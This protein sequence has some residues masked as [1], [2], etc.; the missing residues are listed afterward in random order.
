MRTTRIQLCH[1]EHPS[2]RHPLT[3]EPLIAEFTFRGRPVWPIFGAEDPPATLEDA[4]RRMDSL[5]SDLA[6]ERDRRQ[7]AETREQEARR[8]V[9]ERTVE[10]DRLQQQVNANPADVDRRIAE[11]RT[12][13]EQAGREAANAEWQP[14]L[15]N[16]TAS[17]VVTQA[18]QAALAAG[19]QPEKDAPKDAEG[20]PLPDRVARFL[21]LVDLKDITGDDG[22]V[23]SDELAV[24]IKAA[25]TANPEFAAASTVGAGGRSTF[26]AAPG[27]GQGSQEGGEQVQFGDRVNS[28]VDQMCRTVR[29]PAPTNAGAGTATST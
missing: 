17:L 23:K 1:L 27:S 26:V 4:I 22:T 6:R 28:L 25:A 21:G 7:S 16:A 29:R 18:R 12:Q 19:V 10:R 2:L 9:D 24:R 15:A 14:K 3:G 8:T 11:A 13:G 5:R 20:K